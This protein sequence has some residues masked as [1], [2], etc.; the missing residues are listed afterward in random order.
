VGTEFASLGS[1]CEET[2]QKWREL[3]TEETAHGGTSWK[4][5]Y[6]NEQINKQV[7]KETNKT[8]Q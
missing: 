2:N 6:T 8:E 4:N 7:N 3:H 5:K 1:Q